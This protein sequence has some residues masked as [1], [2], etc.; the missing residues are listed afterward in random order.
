MQIVSFIW[1]HHDNALGFLSLWPKLES[2]DKVIPTQVKPGLTDA[3]H[4]LCAC[5]AFANQ[6]EGKLGWKKPAV[7]IWVLQEANSKLGFRMQRLH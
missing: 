6:E 4:L 1:A 7:L 5:L 3:A 2:Q